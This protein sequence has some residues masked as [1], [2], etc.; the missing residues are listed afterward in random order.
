MGDARILAAIRRE[1]E[2]RLPGG[3]SGLE[4]EQFAEQL[5]QQYWGSRR[6]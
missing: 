2:Q 4:L 6:L 1:L 5:Q 3:L